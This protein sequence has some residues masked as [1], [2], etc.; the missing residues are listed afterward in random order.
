MISVF[1]VLGVHTLSGYDARSQALA[2]ARERAKPEE[3]YRDRDVSPDGRIRRL[4]E[5]V[6]IDLL[7]RVAKACALGRGSSATAEDWFIERARS[8][9]VEH[10]PPA[11]LLMG[12][13]L[14]E[15]GFEPGPR[16]GR[17]LRRVYELQ[18]DGEITT[19]DEALKAARR[20]G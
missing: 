8:L 3:I 13:H 16:L 2:L 18:L 9:G 15:E 6:D 12:R 10:R 11:P 1:D 19:F 5:K 20:L 14:L 7:Y 4:S 17:T